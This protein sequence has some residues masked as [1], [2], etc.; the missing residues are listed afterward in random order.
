MIAGGAGFRCDERHSGVAVLQVHC[1]KCDAPI[2]THVA[3]ERGTVHCWG[4]GHAFDLANQSPI[5]GRADDDSNWAAPAS[6]VRGV[7]RAVQRLTKQ[8]SVVL[9]MTRGA[10]GPQSTAPTRPRQANRLFGWFSRPELRRMLFAA[11]VFLGIPAALIFFVMVVCAPKEEVDAR[12]P[13]RAVRPQAAKANHPSWL[14]KL[15]P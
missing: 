8:T 12:R 5:A 13:V 1:P 6:P 15:R 7:F 2:E 10:G 3:D 11:I 14:Q 9:K 4:C